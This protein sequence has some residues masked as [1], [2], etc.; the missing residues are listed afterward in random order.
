MHKKIKAVRL[1]RETLCSLT[2]AKLEQAAG[3]ATFAGCFTDTCANNTCA[4]NC[5]LRCPSR[6]VVCP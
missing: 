5:T 3:G 2:P 4:A 6:V 1:H